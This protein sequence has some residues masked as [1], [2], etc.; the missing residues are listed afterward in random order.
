MPLT[1]STGLFKKS[2]SLCFLLIEVWK[3]WQGNFNLMPLEWQDPS[4]EPSHGVRGGEKCG[5]RRWT[6][7]LP[8]EVSLLFLLEMH[9]SSPSP[10]PR[11]SPR[12]FLSS[13]DSAA[14]MGHDPR[15]YA[16][17]AAAAAAAA[18]AS[19]QQQQFAAASA[20]AGESIRIVVDHVDVKSRRSS[21]SA[22]GMKL[23]RTLHTSIDVVV[24]ED[25]SL[26]AGFVF[27]PFT[28][29]TCM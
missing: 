5:K 29:S 17:A 18:S 15:S 25:T 4:N 3:V 19:R 7:G 22:R 26:Q 27:Y 14:L 11:L 2:P 13:S 28:Q 21:T 8:T 10:Y 1:G 9:D 24:I 16:S 12:S 6:L 23:G 20:E